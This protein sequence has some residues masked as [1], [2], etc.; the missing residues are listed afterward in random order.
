M[1]R[2]CKFFLLF[3]S[4][5]LIYCEPVYARENSDSTAKSRL[6]HQPNIILPLNKW[7][8]Q[9]VVTKALGSLI[10]SSYGY[11]VEYKNISATDQWGALRKGLVHIQ[12]EVWQASMA[13]DFNRM[14][15]LGYINDMG[16]HSA[17]GKEDWWYPSFVESFCPGLPDWQAMNQCSKLFATPESGDKGVYHAG[18]WDYGDGDIIRA[19]D[20][21]FIINR[22]DSGPEVWKVLDKAIENKEPIMLLNWT[23]NWTDITTKGEFIKFPAYTK[24]CEEDASWGINKT[25]VKDCANPTNGWIKKAVWPGLKQQWPCIEALVENI[26]LTTE[27]IAHASSLVIN[28]GLSEEQAVDLWLKKYDEDVNH[29]L[30]ETCEL[31]S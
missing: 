18:P 16:T 6:K 22:H 24:S 3:F 28:D 4:N 12:L 17:T 23:P 20:L 8:S 11:P 19:L 25:L 14:K 7:M 26:D 27:M 5:I 2:Y 31:T 21:N 15:A 10:R 13:K 1:A 29:W 9:R 30:S